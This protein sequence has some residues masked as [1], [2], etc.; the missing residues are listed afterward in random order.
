M[1]GYPLGWMSHGVRWGST[2]ARAV[3][4]AVALIAVMGEARA[5]VVASWNMNG[6]DP[7]QQT[8]YAANSGT[9]T[10]DFGGLGSSASVL[11]GTTLGATKGELAGDALAAIGTLANA[12]SFRLD[13][14]STDFATSGFSDLM[15]S[16]ATRR[17]ATGPSM[18]RV[19]YWSGLGW[20]TALEFSSN[21]TAWQV[22]TVKFTAAQLLSGG[23]GSLRFVLDGAT[24]TSGSIRFD[25]IAVTGTP[26][27][28]PGALALLGLAGCIGRRRRN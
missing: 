24:S 13:F 16:F 14:G 5:T 7:L 9:G 18:N 20:M 21:A 17:S 6:I 25:N 12:T 4:C 27:P 11:Q 3:A 15:L 22:T 19:E 10:L 1:A 26:A 2:A 28:A 8:V 23:F